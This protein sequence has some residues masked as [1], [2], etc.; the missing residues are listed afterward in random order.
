MGGKLPRRTE[1]AQVMQ[2]TDANQAGFTHGGAIM[3]LVDTAAGVAAM[4]H[5]GTRVVTAAVDSLSFHA[6]VY[7][8]DLVLLTAAVNQA[9]R[10]S[11][12]VEVQV[13]REDPLSGER[14]HTTTAFV[15]MVAVD[16]EGRPVPVP[17]LLP[18]SGEDRRRQQQ[19]E[20]RREARMRLR[21]SLA[22]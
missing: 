4:R 1:M 6:P 13:H 10:T 22:E 8:G 5:A 7:I 19:A 11:M 18:E 20:L 16:E 14:A 21:E 12:E 3:R 9:W 2:V 15:T 17:P